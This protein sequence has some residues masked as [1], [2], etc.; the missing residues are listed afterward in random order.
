[1][2]GI[3]MI[4]YED[5]ILQRQEQQEIYEDVSIG[6]ENYRGCN[7]YI[8]QPAP[9]MMCNRRNKNTIELFCSSWEE[10]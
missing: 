6:F 9:L 4:D 3:Q 2:E 1:M 10:N 8:H 5:L 7:N